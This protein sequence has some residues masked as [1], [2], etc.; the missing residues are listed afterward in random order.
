VV[1]SAG[2]ASL[3][4]NMILLLSLLFGG[5]L[6]NVSTMRSWYAWLHYCSIFFYGFEALMANEFTGLYLNFTV[7]APPAPYYAQCAYTTA[8]CTCA[9]SMFGFLHHARGQASVDELKCWHVCRHSGWL[10]SFFGG[11]GARFSG[12]NIACSIS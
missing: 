11:V 10:D 5:F 8:S 3:A 1:S 12:R 9:C 6:E 4:M 7:W 2:R